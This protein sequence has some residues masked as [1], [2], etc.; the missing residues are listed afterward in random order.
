[1]TAAGQ[2]E[3]VFRSWGGR[4]A[5]AGRPPA[6]GR[7]RVPH[8]RR[9]VHD[10]RV[11]VHV[12]LRESPRLP[13]LRRGALF[14]DVRRALAAAS[15][16]RFRIWQFS[17]QSNH[18][19]LLV[20]AEGATGLARGCQGMA[21]RMARAVNRVLGRRGPVWAER[22]HARWLRT[23]REVRNALLYVLQNARKH[24]A[25]AR[26]M[27]PCSSAAW[28][29]GW[30]TPAPQ[31]PGPAPVRAPRTWLARVGW[32]LHGLLDATRDH[33]RGAGARASPTRT[34]Q[35]LASVQN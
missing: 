14:A 9:P 31:A 5:G 11:P 16:A 8:R 2:G 21:V 22:Y 20:E 24:V 29:T 26:G 30:R 13:S 25:G 4:R 15:G 18:L 17:I 19:H 12:T 33:P 27:D 7:R 35:E 3:L 10:P 28:F 34:R 23:P 32:T 1:M 6:A